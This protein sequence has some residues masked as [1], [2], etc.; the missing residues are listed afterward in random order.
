MAIPISSMPQNMRMLT[1]PGAD[2]NKLSV[3]IGRDEAYQYRHPKPRRLLELEKTLGR[4]YVSF[5]SFTK[6]ARLTRWPKDHTKECHASDTAS[7]SPAFVLTNTCQVS[8]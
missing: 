7:N 1:I 5:C 3:A 6:G 8:T 2:F 4:N